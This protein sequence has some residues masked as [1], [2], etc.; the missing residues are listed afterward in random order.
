MTVPAGYTF[1]LLNGLRVG[2]RLVTTD[3]KPDKLLS[4]L[5]VR[6]NTVVSGEDL[7]A[8]GWSDDP[9][10]GDIKK[11]RG[12]KAALDRHLASGTND[13][14]LSSKGSGAYQLK[15]DE[16]QVDLHDILRRRD[17]AREFRETGDDV[18]ALRQ[19]EPVVGILLKPLNA[20]GVLKRG[21][22]ATWDEEIVNAE[23]LRRN[24]LGDYF[25]V[26]FDKTN[27]DAH[28][29]LRALEA[30]DLDSLPLQPLWLMKI[31]LT[32]EL[33]SP[34]VASE[35][36]SAAK[37]ALNRLSVNHEFDSASTAAIA[38]EIAQRLRSREGKPVYQIVEL[39]EFWRCHRAEPT[40]P[41]ARLRDADR[42][43]G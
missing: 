38:N 40:V 19:L 25:R 35:V 37:I 31:G 11:I 14:V 34:A 13:Y 32:S 2:G 17:L 18:A 23:K 43:P 30:I 36:L 29:F 16:L 28:G 12:N 42:P 4:A 33:K 26:A 39:E 15:L 3:T 41:R 22:S 7:V 27:F 5:L 9:A 24:V 1:S 21:E 8:A 6:V 20:L 10:A